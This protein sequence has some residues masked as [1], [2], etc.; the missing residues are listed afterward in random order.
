MTYY[1]PPARYCGQKQRYATGPEAKA[2]ARH[3]ERKERLPMKEYYCETC[4][5]WHIGHERP[6]K[7]AT[8]RRRL[9]LE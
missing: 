7:R 4:R 6:L 2:A 5:H 8:W 9:G 1:G 3:M